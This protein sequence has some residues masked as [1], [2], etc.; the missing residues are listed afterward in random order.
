MTKIKILNK[1]ETLPQ[2]VSA[3][4]IAA[5]VK[6]QASKHFLKLKKFDKITT[7]EQR[8]Q[9]MENIKALKDIKA[10]GIKQKKEITDALDRASKLV[11]DLFKPFETEVDNAE[12]KGK[13]LI[14]EFDEEVEK[15][16]LKLQEDFKKGKIKSVS[17]FTELTATLE[18]KATGSRKTWQVF[19]IDENKVPR[20]FMEVD[21]SKI[22]QAFKDGKKV[23]GCE[24]KQVKGL[25]I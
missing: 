14:L 1:K 15:K 16:K 25:S 10:E 3:E 11:K 24:Y 7:T 8:A 12:I 21:E 5:N 9:V 18:T 6:K 4:V 20:E 13:E 22:E 19:V 2:K 23:P 17:E